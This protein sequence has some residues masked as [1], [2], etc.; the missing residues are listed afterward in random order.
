MKFF[1]HLFPKGFISCFFRRTKISTNYLNPYFHQKIFKLG[2]ESKVYKSTFT[3]TRSG[4]MNLTFLGCSSG[5]P[6]KE[7]NV[8]AICFSSD[9]GEI[10]LFDCGEGTQHQFQ[11]SSLKYSKLS[12]IFITHLHGD[13]VCIMDGQLI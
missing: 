10:L 3:Q 7:R 13:H 11:K 8:S 6:C 5:I 2:I 9:V 1:P 12:A 4:S